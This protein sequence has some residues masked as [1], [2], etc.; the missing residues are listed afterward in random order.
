MTKTLNFSAISL[1]AT[2]I[3]LSLQAPAAT[4]TESLKAGPGA[5]AAESPEVQ[6]QA[7]E[8]AKAYAY[9]RQYP[10]SRV[11]QDF[12]LNCK[13]QATPNRF[14]QVIETT[15][16]TEAVDSIPYKSRM[17]FFNAIASLD[18]EAERA[19][20]CPKAV[21][22]LANVVKEIKSTRL[23]AR[24]LYWQWVCSKL[25]NKPDPKKTQA[26]KDELWLKYPFSY[27]ALLAMDKMADTRL[28]AV[29]TEESDMAIDFRSTTNPAMNDI[30]VGIEALVQL[31]EDGAA[32]IVA[33]RFES[34]I[35]ALEPSVQLYIATLMDKVSR[36]V[37]STLPITRSL[38]DLLVRYP[39]M[40]SA[41]T[42]K[43]LFPDDYNMRLIR[44][45][46]DVSFKD[47]LEEL[48]GTI[49]WSLL[50]GLIHQESALNPRAASSAN[51]YGLT[52]LLIPTAQDV[53]NIWP[54]RPL[55]PVSREMLF[56]PKISIQLGV[57][58]F[59]R[60][61]GTFGGSLPL[62]LASY[63]A[64]ETGVADWI[65]RSAQKL[66]DE[67]VIADILFLN[68]KRDSRISE[69]SAAILAKEYWYRLLYRQMHQAEES[70]PVPAPQP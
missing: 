27:Q 30:I 4:F 61:L 65:Q 67:R 13:R 35:H 21:K 47:L 23:T 15:K 22:D 46:R 34:D 7:L 1:V 57:L 42:L 24:A 49:D 18:N 5:F 69:Y 12:V 44:E 59:Q 66:T 17:Q 58:D 70:E 45:A 40:R 55:F 62:A 51:A 68:E 6:S 39:A 36:M 60:R 53:Y 16:T 26:L 25:G 37:P 41:T 8:E 14:C 38:Q 31:E 56:D 54:D 19:K 48:R 43:L 20:R 9:Y 2:L 33:R 32:A 11:G 52:Q 29:T 64:G 28:L 63:N 10:D 50:A 3:G